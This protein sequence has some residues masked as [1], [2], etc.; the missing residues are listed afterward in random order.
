MARADLGS[1][2]GWIELSPAALRQMRHALEAGETGV[3][4][5]VGV[6]V[7]HAGYANRFFPGTSV[8]QTRARYVFFTCWNYLSQ[9]QRVPVRAGNATAHKERA[10]LWVT[11]HLRQFQPRQRGIIGTR[12]YPKPPAQP[13]DFIYW[14]AL[15]SFG[16]YRGV[17]RSRLL[18]HWDPHRIRRVESSSFS[19]EQEG[20]EPDQLGLF[21]CPPVPR[22][23]QKRS[24]PPVTF[25]LTRAEAELL[26]GRLE[27]LGANCLLAQA[28]RRVHRLRPSGVRLWG[29]PLIREAAASSG[30]TDRVRR[31]QM[32]S[33]LARLVRAI[34]A[35]LVERVVWKTSS[36]AERRRRAH[37]DFY[38]DEL[39][40]FWTSRRERAHVAAARA[41][42]MAQLHEDIPKL[43]SNRD[44]SAMLR[45]V[46]ERLAD[47]RQPGDVPRYLLDTATE[48]KFLTVEWQRKRERARLPQTA[49]GKERRRD[50]TRDTVKIDGLDYRWRQVR[51]LLED[52]R[53][54]LLRGEHR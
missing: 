26:R 9:S 24:A 23:W 25:R 5:E 7:I 50:F 40:H 4:D 54:G 33:S 47:V 35:A 3:V 18:A 1:S 38:L 21:S 8:L 41:L 12:V 28:A 34:Y 16:F 39:R 13:P 53:A 27:A 14:T 10:E 42:D 49:E 30:D 6:L 51:I 11:E 19:E 52:L 17:N 48:T 20:L 43:A 2:V 15:R 32:A 45:H 36:P 46:M 44:L 31:A 37:P 29:D 22:W